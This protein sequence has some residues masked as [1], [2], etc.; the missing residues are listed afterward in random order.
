MNYVGSPEETAAF[1][2]GA[3][4]DADRLGVMDPFNEKMTLDVIKTMKSE[5]HPQLKALRK[6]YT[7]EQIVDL[8]NSIAQKQPQQ[9]MSDFDQYVQQTRARMGGQYRKFL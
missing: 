1:L 2:M 9:Q 8:W 7:D 3:R 6:T 4:Y 5:D